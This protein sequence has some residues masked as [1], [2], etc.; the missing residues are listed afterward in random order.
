MATSANYSLPSDPNVSSRP[1]FAELTRYTADQFGQLNDWRTS[2]LTGDYASQSE[3]KSAQL[4]LPDKAQFATCMAPS[5]TAPLLAVG[6]GGPGPNL[7]V[8]KAHT[9]SLESDDESLP[10]M[11]LRAQTSS[12]HPIHSISFSDRQIITG[13]DRG[14]NMLYTVDTEAVM[15]AGTGGHS[16]AGSGLKAAA[17]FRNKLS[18]APEVPV[19]GKYIS[20]RRVLHTD[21]EPVSGQQGAGSSNTSGLRFL[22]AVGHLVHVWDVNDSK[23]PIRDDRLIATGSIDKSISILDIR[24]RGKPVVWKTRNGHQA[25]INDIQWSPFVPYWL[26]SAGDD[27]NTNIWDLRYL[28]GPAYTI[29]QHQQRF[30]SICWSNTHCDMITTG[31]ADNHWRLWALRAGS[32]SEPSATQ[33]VGG[34]EP[35]TALAPVTSSLIANYSKGISGSIES[36]CCPPVFDNTYFTCSSKGVLTSFQLT[37]EAYGAVAIH[38]FGASTHPNQYEI[39]QLVYQRDYGDA[40]SGF[41]G[42]V[43]GVDRQPN[44]A[45][46]LVQLSKALLPKDPITWDGWS[47][48]AMPNGSSSS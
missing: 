14:I 37:E 26:A 45:T 39:E 20:S 11:E 3:L 21:F 19:P 29:Q 46:E 42:L 10:T 24:K 6:S 5:Q 9:A 15:G 47:L 43:K 32:P 44:G 36:I 1:G 12:R 18:R 41:N 48:P 33:N 23:A 34:S 13:N 30:T 22:S 31:S 40:I 25:P 2:F 7:F 17:T 35:R 28:S 8:L 16:E 4:T 27:C 38:R